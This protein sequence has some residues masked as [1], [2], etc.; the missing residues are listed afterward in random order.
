MGCI[1]TKNGVSHSK[2]GESEILSVVFLIVLT[3]T[4]TAVIVVTGTATLGDSS[5]RASFE[6]VEN[7][8]TSFDSRSSKVA[9][10]SAPVQT[11]DFGATDDGRYTVDSTDGWIRVVHDNHTAGSDDTE[12]IYDE[13]LGSVV[14]RNRDTSI[15]YRGGGVW[16]HDG[17]G[18]VVVSP[19]EFRYRD[20]TLTLPLV[21]TNGSD[22][23]AGSTKGIV[24]RDGSSTQVYPDPQRTMARAGP[25]GIPSSKGPST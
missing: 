20:Q 12:T 19:P 24:S 17:E 10:G 7:A 11:I 16:R 1:L 15:A 25:T 3:I 8:M 4:G 23:T 14:Y 2:R 5:D 6:R 22:T 13:S 9:L 21:V 18:S